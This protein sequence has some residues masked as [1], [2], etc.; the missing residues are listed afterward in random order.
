MV[1]NGLDQMN[2]MPLYEFQFKLGSTAVPVGYDNGLVDIYSQIHL[3]FDWIGD[4]F[5]FY[6][7]YK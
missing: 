1:L 3:I 6:S 5:Q 4:G 7:G 2:N